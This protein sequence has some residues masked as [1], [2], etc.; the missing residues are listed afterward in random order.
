MEIQSITLQYY[1]VYIVTGK[2]LF[3]VGHLLVWSCYATKTNEDA[4]Y[5][6]LLTTGT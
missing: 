3:S 2:D 6:L 1:D 4:S 5:P